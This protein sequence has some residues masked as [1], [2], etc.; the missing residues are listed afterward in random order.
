MKVVNGLEMLRNLERSKQNSDLKSTFD[1][2]AQ[3]QIARRV[4]A[5]K[6]HTKVQ[7]ALLKLSRVSNNIIWHC[8]LN[9]PKQLQIMSLRSCVHHAQCAT[10]HFPD[11]EWNCFHFQATCFNLGKIKHAVDNVKK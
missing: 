3:A 9:V 11:T 6:E 1:Q 10:N 7:K 4:T 8:T 2:G 5:M